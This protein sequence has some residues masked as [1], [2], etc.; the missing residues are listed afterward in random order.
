MTAFSRRAFCSRMVAVTASAVLVLVL[1]DTGAARAQQ[2]P[3]PLGV[4]AT[5]VR[6]CTIQTP[7]A[8]GLP[9]ALPTGAAPLPTG[10]GPVQADGGVILRCTAVTSLNPSPAASGRP[11][12]STAAAS[13]VAAR[14]ASASTTLS[15]QF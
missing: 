9:T 13:T 10:A 2:P 4:T 5:V 15:I 8:T 1:L 14:P 6:T 11:V 12:M 7:S 3:V